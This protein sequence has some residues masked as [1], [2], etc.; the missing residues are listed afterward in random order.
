MTPK[1]TGSRDALAAYRARIAAFRWH[2]ARQETISQAA[3]GSRHEGGEEEKRR[4]E[5][6]AQ[7]NVVD[8]VGSACLNG[9]VSETGS[10]P[11]PCI[12]PVDSDPYNHLEAF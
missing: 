4:G 3:E 5:E 9:A 11:T 1:V 8:F 2:R 6:E 12:S 10:F 7:E